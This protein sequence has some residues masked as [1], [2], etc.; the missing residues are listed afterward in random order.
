MYKQLITLSIILFSLLLFAGTA[1][2]HCEI[3][4][5]IYDDQMRITL[6]NE[7]IA[8]IE[9]SMDKINNP[10]DGVG[11]QLAWGAGAGGC[12]APKYSV[13]EPLGAYTSGS[14]LCSA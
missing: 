7:H 10:S 5:G 11:S 1:A 14:Q 6:L 12:L 9:K 8:T 4:C 3:P 13:T 2:S